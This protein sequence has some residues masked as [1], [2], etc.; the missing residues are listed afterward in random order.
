MKIKVSPICFLQW[1]QNL[2]NLLSI[3]YTMAWECVALYGPSI[4]TFLRLFLIPHTQETHIEYIPIPN[5]SKPRKLYV[6]C[7]W[8]EGERISNKKKIWNK[9]PYSLLRMKFR[10]F[11]LRVERKS[12]EKGICDT[13]YLPLN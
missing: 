2:Y 4:H 10:F 1:N 9:N 7:W 11:Y 3:N 12:V 8:W 5:T 13:N 6:I